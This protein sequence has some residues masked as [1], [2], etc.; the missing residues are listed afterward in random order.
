V[1]KI[2]W[3]VSTVQFPFRAKKIGGP[4]FFW[5]AH[6][7]MPLSAKIFW[8]PRVKKKSVGGKKET[9]KMEKKMTKSDNKLK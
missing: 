3:I 4:I 9:N 2:C 1:R 7:L 6:Y 5:T 8:Q